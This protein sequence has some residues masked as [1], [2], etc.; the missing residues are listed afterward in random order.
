[1]F[2]VFQLTLAASLLLLT[3]PAISWT[4]P[5]SFITT[6]YALVF[7]NQGLT[8]IRVYW[9]FDEMYSSMTG[10]DFDKDKDGTFNTQESDELVQLAIAHLPPFHFFTNIEIDG[11]LFPVNAVSDFKI[12][13]ESGQLDYEFFVPCPVPVKNQIQTIKIAPYDPEYSAA[14]FFATDQPVFLEKAENFKLDISIGEDPNK[15]IFFDMIHPETLTL[16]F[17]NKL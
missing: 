12:T 17:Q 7:D 5:H 3:L 15:T 1:M 2:R 13:F 9:S 11:R 10:G 14:M 16:T 6:S 4:H 8:G